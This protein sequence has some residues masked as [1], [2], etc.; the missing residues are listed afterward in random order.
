MAFLPLPFQKLLFR[1][2]RLLRALVRMGSISDNIY[3]LGRDEAETARYVEA[4]YFI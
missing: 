4:I 3:L 1:L 2:S